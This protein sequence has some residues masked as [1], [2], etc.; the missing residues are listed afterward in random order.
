MHA[1]TVKPFVPPFLPAPVLF[2]KEELLDW[3]GASRN[4]K[5]HVLPFCFF[6]NGTHSFLFGFLVDEPIGRGGMDSKKRSAKKGRCVWSFVAICCEAAL[7]LCH[8]LTDYF[9]FLCPVYRYYR[10]CF[11]ILSTAVFLTVF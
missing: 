11:G 2:R 8:S 9:M 3:F 6:N 5:K 1:A 10:F 4:E 7:V